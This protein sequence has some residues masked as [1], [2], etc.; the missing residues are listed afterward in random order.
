M[1]KAMI[2]LALVL[3]GCVAVPSEPVEPVEPVEPIT[4]EERI[5]ALAAIAS[6]FGADT[7]MTEEQAE[8]INRMCVLA[9][10]A[11]LLAG[12]RVEVPPSVEAICD[13][14]AGL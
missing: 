8:R 14:A 11:A 6:E 13:E 3:A 10:H 12:Y 1:F 2:P 7:E 4:A 5:E 9:V